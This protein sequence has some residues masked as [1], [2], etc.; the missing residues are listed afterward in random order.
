MTMDLT[1]GLPARQAS[2]GGVRQF[3]RRHALLT[4][5]ALAYLLS[6]WPILLEPHSLV[7][8]G[9]FLAALIVLPLI[10]GRKALADFAHAAF[11]WRAAPRWYLLALGVPVAITALA[12]G[13]TLLL[14]ASFDE[15]RPDRPAIDVLPTFIQYVIMVGIGEELAWR[16][17]AL[18]RL[19]QGRS[20]LSAALILGAIHALWHWPLADGELAYQDILP[21]VVGI[22]SFSVFTAWMYVR[23]RGSLLFP[24][25]AHASVNT[26][27]YFTFS[28]FD[29]DEK[30]LLFSLWAIGWL[31]VAA[32]IALWS[33]IRHESGAS[34]P[35]AGKEATAEPD[36]AAA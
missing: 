28:R 21:E 5:F 17:V 12:Y 13:V 10:G 7:P 19:M 32:S 31:I 16:G 2:V 35:Y 25:L 29:G 3:V 1:L 27:A 33:G 23:V 9:P 26:A 22:V 11:Q 34:L 4:F 30:T 8:L 15:A 14:G 36:Y 24:L 18:P 20:I 6:Q